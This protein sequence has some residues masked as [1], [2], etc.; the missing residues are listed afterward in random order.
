MGLGRGAAVRRVR[1]A[2]VR[3]RGVG[4]GVLLSV[5]VGVA[6]VVA[7]ALG[8]GLGLGLDVVRLIQVPWLAR[9]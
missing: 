3:R 7:L 8:L 4:V 5:A 9:L 2:A 1:R 6:V